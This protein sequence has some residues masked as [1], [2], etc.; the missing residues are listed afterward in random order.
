MENYGQVAS[1]V[2]PTGVLLATGA[3]RANSL[4]VH[5]AA[6]AAVPHRGLRGG[7]GA[8]F[9]LGTV[10]VTGEISTGAIAT[11]RNRLLRA[12][13]GTYTLRA[14]LTKPLADARAR[15]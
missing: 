5:L 2:H 3:D 8:A 10:R 1:M 11:F 9:D 15:R 7:R 14:E 6:V 4:S 13:L 12:R